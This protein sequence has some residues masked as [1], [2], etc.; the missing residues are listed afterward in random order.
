MDTVSQPRMDLTI[1]TDPFDETW[2]ALDLETTGL[3]PEKD[4][5]IE[6]GAVKFRTDEVLDTFQTF[7][8]PERRLSEFITD[9]TGI[10]QSDVDAAPPFN[11]VSGEL[12]AFIGASSLVG[13]NLEFDLGFLRA[14]GVSPPNATCDTWDLAYVLRPKLGAYTL[15]SLA[16]R[17]GARHDRPHRAVDDADATRE[18]FVA[19]LKELA[20][21]DG[22][23]LA[24][25]A[26]LAERSGWRLRPVLQSIKPAAASRPARPKITDFDKDGRKIA[27]EPGVSGIDVKA[28][29]SRLARG[30]P[31]R[32]NAVVEPVGVDLVESVLKAGSGF[33]E[34]IARFEERDEQVE[35]ARA[36][37]ETLNEG[38]RLVV[39]AGTGVGKSMAYLLPAAIYAAQNNRRVVVSTNTINL[40]EQLVGKDL[41]ML[42]EG[43]AK[44]PE[45]AGIDLK[46]TQLKGR[47]NYMCLRKW[48]H[49]RN[50]DGIAEP[51]ARMVAK[52]LMWLRE[53]ETG[54]RTE[55]NLGH[56]AAA[57]PWD[58]LSA[59]GA[60]ECMH[61][62]GPCFLR[63]AR[64]KAAASHVVVVNHAL[65]LSDL[66]MGGTVIPEY[67]VLIV[68][69]AHH[70]E[71]EATRQLGFALPQSAFDEHLT[72][73]GGDRGVF[74]EA[75]SIVRKSSADELQRKAVEEGTTK[76]NKQIA[77]LREALARLFSGVDATLFADGQSRRDRNSDVRVS[78]ATRAQP[79]WS[80]LEILWHNADL[81]LADLGSSLEALHRAV[82]GLDG[83]DLPGYEGIMTELTETSQSNGMLRHRLAEFVANPEED[84]IY[85]ATRALQSRDIELH[86]A[87]LHVGETLD[88]TL[89]S[90]KESVVLTSATLSANG[91]FDHLTERVGF[92]ESRELLLG[93]P[94][95]Y[96]HAAL[97]CT[98]RDMHQPS[99]PDYQEAV[100]DA[101]AQAAIAAGGRTMALFTSH[102]AL[103]ACASSLRS[104][105]RTRGL[106]VLAQGVDGTPQQLVG[107][108]V[109]QPESVLLGTSSFWEGVDLAGN[110]LRVLLV[111]RLPF[112]VPTEPV[113]A[114][115]SELYEN[116][117][118]QYSVPQAI[119]RLR[120]GFGRLI[121]TR[122]DRGVAII[123]DQRIVSKRYGREFISSLPPVTSN[124]C[125]LED[126]PSEI[127]RWLDR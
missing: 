49:L 40:Q 57:A 74:N 5:I 15:G 104:Y 37:A 36:V 34:A 94:F 103:R 47:A 53:T 82:S 28:M 22:D 90:T 54:D 64:E 112:N 121:R 89:Y 77:P 27:G 102:A 72:R 69:E 91:T 35:M 41:P 127:E 4:K 83:A 20:S 115:R 25:M 116:P 125:L 81:L 23:T 8:N 18:V 63:A 84:G 108:F 110:V 109:R 67:D 24:E 117:F 56:R 93:S 87:P 114:A 38:G 124:A 111:A 75:V 76:A 50:A 60:Q 86:A 101:V 19:L 43:L 7:V 68:D 39:E 113:F 106:S 105:L 73:L 6:I 55:L 95:D 126:I 71:D 107:R 51:E 21:L 62:G 29:A 10:R 1:R 14:N 65:L 122:S 58:R 119:L 79:G 52:T 3:A 97:L 66:A 78:K 31:I 44:V 12:L 61:T 100:N 59:Q 45:A 32:P 99:S 80:D 2:V 46:Y 30:R 118:T 98:P 16:N 70:L 42:V 13:H 85:W 11:Q 120:Q 48:Q 17:F 92:Q 88:K 33:S 123:L 26:R 9:Y 96:E